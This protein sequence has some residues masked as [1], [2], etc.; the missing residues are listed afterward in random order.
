MDHK[1]LRNSPNA[2]SLL[3][4]GRWVALTAGHRQLGIKKGIDHQPR[5][6]AR[7][8]KEV[9]VSRTKSPRDVVCDAREGEEQ[10]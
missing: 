3:D 10:P 4:W 7:E 8:R 9:R 5:I 2:Y 6:R 1:N